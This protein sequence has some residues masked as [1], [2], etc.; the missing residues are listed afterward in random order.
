MLHMDEDVLNLKLCDILANTLD[1]C[2][3]NKVFA[4]KYETE[5]TIILNYLLTNKKLTN[6]QRTYKKVNSE[7]NNLRQQNILQLTR[8]QKH[9]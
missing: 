7:I 3:V 4:E 1:L 9:S 5:T 2:N 8:N 6:S